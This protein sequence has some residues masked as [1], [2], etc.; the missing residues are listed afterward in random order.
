MERKRN[1]II[2]NLLA[3]LFYLS[4]Y[5]T[6]LNAQEVTI[7]I[8]D[9]VTGED[10]LQDGEAEVKIHITT[11]V[12]IYSYSFT[13]EGFNNVL[14]ANSA[15]IQPDCM[16]W[17]FFGAENINILEDYFYGGGIGGNVI[18]IT[19]NGEFLSIIASYNTILDDEDS[20]Y[21][22]FN[23]VIPGIGFA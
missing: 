14:S 12:P 9:V 23:E 2:R 6:A 20:Y 18:P 21:L 11:S 22:T 4:L 1:I 13:L 19:T 8:D 3:L 7:W 10:Y 15:S 17:S 5:S 16:A